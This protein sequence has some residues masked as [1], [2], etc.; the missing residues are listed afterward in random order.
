MT[1]TDPPTT[2]GAAS[3]R[4]AAVFFRRVAF[5]FAGFV[6]SAIAGLVCVPQEV[7]GNCQSITDKTERGFN[8]SIPQSIFNLQSSIPS[9]SLRHRKPGRKERILQPIPHPLGRFVLPDEAQGVERPERSL[10]R[11]RGEPVTLENGSSQQLAS[12]FLDHRL[13]RFLLHLGQALPHLH[14][15]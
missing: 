5:F 13:E 15:G 9:V 3:P 6:S 11:R 1:S 7:Q 8:P 14:V 4:G 2:S 10:Q 12:L